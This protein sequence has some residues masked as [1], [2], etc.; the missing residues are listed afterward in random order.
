MSQKCDVPMSLLVFDRKMVKLT[1]YFTDGRLKLDSLSDEIQRVRQGP[2]RSR[3]NRVLLI[4]SVDANVRFQT[5]VAPR[6]TNQSNANEQ[7]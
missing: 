5:Y 3:R 6:D 1:E 4:K 7:T 2:K